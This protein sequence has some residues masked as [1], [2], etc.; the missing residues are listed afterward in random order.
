MSPAELTLLVLFS[1]LA[2]VTVFGSF[3]LNI[4]RR[5]SIQGIENPQAAEAYDRISRMPPFELI[6]RGVVKRLKKYADRGTITD[7]G[8][9]PGYL[10]QK[11]A[12]QMPENNIAGVDISEEMIKR[13]RANSASKGYGNRIQFRQG[14]ADHLPFDDNT[15]DFIVSTLS[16]HHWSD[17]Q[18]A[19]KEIQRVLK[20]G[21]QMLILDLRRDARRLFLWLMWFAQNVAL[22]TIGAGALGRINEPTGSLI[23]SYTEKEL[24]E[25]MK[26]TTF[27]NYEIEGRLGWIYI[28][29]KKRKHR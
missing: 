11:I 26:K 18:S 1:V 10:L 16:L 22:R 17:P 8:C 20:P 3:R 28:W 12:E 13:A 14:A 15:Q 7:V 5:A 21:G 2:P 6:R 19:L 9:G 4:P 27:N 29:A 24:E 23:A 25:I